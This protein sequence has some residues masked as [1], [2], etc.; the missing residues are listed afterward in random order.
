MSRQVRF[1]SVSGVA[2]HG[3]AIVL[4]QTLQQFLDYD[5]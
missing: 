5:L 3:M 2:F 4:G 1:Q